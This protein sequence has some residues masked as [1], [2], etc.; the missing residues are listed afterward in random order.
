MVVNVF[1]RAGGSHTTKYTPVLEV[2]SETS[3]EKWPQ[4]GAKKRRQKS[5]KGKP[6]EFT[7]FVPFVPFVAVSVCVFVAN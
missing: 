6:E 3:H 1:I 2:S 4:Y 5:Q 7:I